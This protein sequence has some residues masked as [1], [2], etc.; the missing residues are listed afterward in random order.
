MGN[1]NRDNRGGGGKFGNKSFGRGNFGGRDSRPQ[2]H[3]AVCSKCGKRCQVPFRPTGERPI[4]CSDCFEKER[5]QT[6]QRTGGRDFDRRDSERPRSEEKRMYQTTCSKCGAKCEVPFLPTGGRP[7]YCKDCFERGVTTDDRKNTDSYKDQFASLNAKL[8]KLIIILSP[9]TP[10]S[11]PAD[12]T[13]PKKEI[14]KS[15]KKP[16]APKKGKK[17]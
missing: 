11:A 5:D 10:S 7:T 13:K 4:F 15:T 1:F 12:S 17:K 6:P 3:D 14:K 9:A 8:D 16:V 2:M